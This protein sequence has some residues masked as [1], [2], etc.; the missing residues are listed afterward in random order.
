MQVTGCILLIQMTVA[1]R[2]GHM[3]SAKVSYFIS[4]KQLSINKPES[5]YINV[6]SAKMA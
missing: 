1:V 6:L 3:L 4:N 5:E 2:W